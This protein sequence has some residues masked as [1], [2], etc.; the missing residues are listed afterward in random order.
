MTST[1]CT[2]CGA[3]HRRLSSLR[4]CFKYNNKTSAGKKGS[5][6][7]VWEETRVKWLKSIERA[8]EMKTRIWLQEIE[9]FYTTLWWDVIIPGVS[10]THTHMY[11][12]IY[13]CVAGIWWDR[14]NYFVLLYYRLDCICAYTQTHT[15]NTASARLYRPSWCTYGNI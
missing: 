15:D 4:T 10:L 14:I 3:T 9:I 8:G 5:W 13:G 2:D 12:L 7:K 1:W 11:C 6:N